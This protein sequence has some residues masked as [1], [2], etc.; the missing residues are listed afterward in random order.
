MSVT[1]VHTDHDHLTV[2]VIADF[3]APIERV[4]E[5]WSNPR[6]LERWWGPPAYPATF[7]KHDLIPGVAKPAQHRTREP[8]VVSVWRRV[9][10]G[11]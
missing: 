1:S 11:G 2:T 5:L 10:N 4:W 9:L 8:V 7:E 6:K 3:G